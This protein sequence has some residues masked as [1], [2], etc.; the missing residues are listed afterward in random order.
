[1]IDL[2]LFKYFFIILDDQ[3]PG[4]D[5]GNDLTDREMGGRVIECLR[6]KYV[7]THFTLQSQCVTELVDVIQT[8]KLDVKLDVRLYRSCKSYLTDK[9][10]GIEPEDCLKLLYQKGEIR[11]D[12]CREQIKRIIREGQADIHVDRALA[13]ACQADITKYCIDI[14]IGS[15]KQLQCLISMGKSVTPQCANMLLKR[16]ELWDSVSLLI[17]IIDMHTKKNYSWRFQLEFT[18]H[19]R[20][21]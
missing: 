6:K 10:T 3:N 19:K 11:D 17:L 7:D 1:M 2:D 16:K 4:A 12:D 21:Y 20:N 13:F 8:S 15:G 14:P 9:C 5:G 18:D